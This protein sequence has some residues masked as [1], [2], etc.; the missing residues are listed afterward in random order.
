M[1]GKMEQFARSLTVMLMLLGLPGMS[2]IFEARANSFAGTSQAVCGTS[3][4]AGIAIGPSQSIGYHHF[5]LV[6][7]QAGTMGASIP[8][9]LVFAADNGARLR[10]ATITGTNSAYA[11]ASIANG[12]RVFTTGG[13]CNAALPD[14]DTG[15]GQIVLGGVVFSSVYTAGVGAD[16]LTISNDAGVAPT[17]VVS[18]AA[19]AGSDLTYGEYAAALTNAIHSVFRA[20]HSTSVTAAM[21]SGSN[22]IVTFANL[23]A[24][25]PA[26]L[27]LDTDT[28]LTG[29]KAVIAIGGSLT[30]VAATTNITPTKF[31]DGDFKLVAPFTYAH[32]AKVAQ[33]TLANIVLD[34]RN[35]PAGDGVGIQL[36]PS[37][38]TSGVTIGTSTAIAILRT[39]VAFTQIV[40]SS[41]SFGPISDRT[42]VMQLYITPETAGRTGNYYAAAQ[43]ANGQWYFMNSAGDFIPYSGGSLPILATGT[44]AG[45]GVMVLSHANVAPFVG[46]MVYVGFGLD[47]ADMLKNG[48]YLA[49]DVR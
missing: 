45:R 6:E 10:A 12:G 3:G 26:T 49:A 11:T 34:T 42:M 17:S 44:L 31:I 4:G 18:S 5:T 8:G 39:D 35:A 20:L 7:N 15:T 16:T 13:N 14:A 22:G 27:V 21:G 9:N 40:C 30:A 2:P 33:L 46:A 32:G 25:T 36:D 28:A 43:L 48:Y 29:G 24:A 19:T 37:T 41:V 38:T 47:E 23:N 1:G